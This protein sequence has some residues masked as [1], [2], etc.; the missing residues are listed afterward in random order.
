MPRIQP[1]EF[2]EALRALVESES[3]SADPAAVEECGRCLAG[4]GARITGLQPEAV[5]LDEGPSALRWSTGSARAEGRVLL[6]GHRDTVWP[7]GTLSGRPFA[8]DGGRARGPGVF[9]MKAGLLVGLYALTRVGADTPVTFLVTGDEE[10]GS[11]ASWRLIEAEARSARAVLVLEGAARG[12]ALKHARKGWSIYTLRV[13]GRAAHAGLEPEAG[14][15]ALIR[16]AE[17]VASLAELNAPEAGVTTTPTRARAGSTVNT[18][19][20]QAELSVD[21]R[22]PSA[23]E[24]RRVDEAIRGLAGTRGGVAV[25]V[26]GG[27]NR[28][29][30]EESAAAPLL[31]RVPGAAAAAGLACP[32]SAAVGGISDANITAALGV[33]TLDGLGAVG[34]GPHAEHE[35]VDL[36]PTASRIGLLAALVEDLARRPVESVPTGEE[37][38][39]PR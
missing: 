14:R 6:L 18:V 11:A 33:P 34:G 25:G 7:R 23:A 19:P 24:Q 8:V 21:V 35:W 29:P 2:A 31:R 26:E 17:L 32:A 9:D 20:D 4:L 39:I 1:G 13:A 37:E 3:P 10:I 28:P 30:M 27:I 12:G 5:P 15:N 36:E 38:V 22:A 16:L